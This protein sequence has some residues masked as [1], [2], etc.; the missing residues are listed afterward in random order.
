MTVIVDLTPR[1]DGRP[2]QIP[3]MAPCP[4]CPDAAR[5]DARTWRRIQKTRRGGHYGRVRLEAGRR[6]RPAQRGLSHRPFP[7][8]TTGRRPGH[9]GA[10]PPATG[11]HRQTRRQERPALRLPGSPF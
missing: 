10:L 5:M 3:D 1:A 11:D 6:V 2:A 4:F 9:Q 8:R 7:R